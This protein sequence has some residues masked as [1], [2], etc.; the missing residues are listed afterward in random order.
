[1]VPTL[2]GDRE[3]QASIFLLIPVGVVPKNIKYDGSARLRVNSSEL[4][5]SFFDGS[6][7][8]QSPEQTYQFDA[9]PVRVQKLSCSS[10]MA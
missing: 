8:R 3:G 2:H 10:H 5:T 6:V 4:V 7:G 1:M 9:V